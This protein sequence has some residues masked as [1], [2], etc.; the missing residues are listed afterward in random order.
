MRS[1]CCSLF[2]RPPR[3]RGRCVPLSMP[4]PLRVPRL[5]AQGGIGS[6]SAH[7]P[8]RSARASFSSSRNSLFS[9][10]YFQYHHAHPARIISRLILCPSSSTMSASKRP[11][12]HRPF[13]CTRHTPPPN[14]VN[15]CLLAPLYPGCPCSGASIPHNLNVIVFPSQSFTKIVSPSCTLTTTTEELPKCILFSSIN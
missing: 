5:H 13:F 15:K 10:S 6:S 3:V 12:T 9:G 7:S 2:A 4:V 8:R 11:Y 1:L 14:S